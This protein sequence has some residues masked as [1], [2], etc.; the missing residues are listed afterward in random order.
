MNQDIKMI[1]VHNDSKNDG[2]IDFLFENLNRQD[3]LDLKVATPDEMDIINKYSKK[4]ENDNIKRKEIAENIKTKTYMSEFYDYTLDRYEEELE[5]LNELKIDY[6]VENYELLIKLASYFADKGEIII[7]NFTLL[8][9]LNIAFNKPLF[10]Q[11]LIPNSDIIIRTNGSSILK[12]LTAL[13][14]INLIP[15]KLIIFLT[16]TSTVSIVPF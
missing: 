8:S 12:L 14:T 11:I 9:G 1:V 16:V 7:F 4:I 3:K 13:P 5:K 15:S 10:S 6:N 2:E